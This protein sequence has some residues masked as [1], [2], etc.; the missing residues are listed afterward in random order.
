MQATGITRTINHMTSDERLK[1]LEQLQ[2]K[3]AIQQLKG[4]PIPKHLVDFTIS[5]LQGHS[6]PT[7]PGYHSVHHH[8]NGK[9][10]IYRL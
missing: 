6:T 9:V 1:A 8:R 3:C 5:R 10:E 2:L 4:I 7:P